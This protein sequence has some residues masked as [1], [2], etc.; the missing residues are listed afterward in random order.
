MAASTAA[1]RRCRTS[2]R[3]ADVALGIYA[4]RHAQALVSS[5]GRLARNPLATLL[6]VLVLAL[7]LAL[8]L[9]LDVFVMNAGAATGGFS[10]AVDLSVYFKTDVPLAKVQQ[11]A[12]N[13]RAHPGIADATVI[14]AEDGLNEFKR[15]SGFGAALQ[16]LQEN[17]LPHVL[18]VHPKGDAQ[19]SAAIDALERYFTAWPEVD[20]VQMDADWVRRFN[21]LLALM[22]HLLVLAAALLGAGVLA[23]VGNT[24]RLEIQGRREE[25]EVT[26]LVGGS[27]GFVR[28]PFLYTGILYGV[29]GSLAAWLI[30]ALS[31]A[32]LQAPVSVLGQLYGSHFAL[33]GPTPQ[34]VG[35]LI[36][37]GVVLGW[38]GAWIAAYRHLRDAE[39]RA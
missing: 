3:P 5:I 38:L 23:I 22:Q 36:A 8:P 13:A 27:N 9:A 16:G 26:K 29:L 24:I 30:V 2:W 1:S 7:A 14:S 37:A 25:I 33:T 18:R 28:R 17:P 39:P 6:T 11:L 20:V 4:G 21:A 35:V 32:S 34:D 31:V 19:S 15:Y 10:N 12:A